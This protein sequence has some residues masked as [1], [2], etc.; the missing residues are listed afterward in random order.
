MAEQTAASNDGWL[1]LLGR[2]A[3]Y[4]T[5]RDNNKTAERLAEIN[6]AATRLPSSPSLPSF[7]FFPGAAGGVTTASGPGISNQGGGGG[8]SIAPFIPLV[9]LTLVG[10]FA[11]KMLR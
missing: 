8:F 4:L 2:G 11:W 5:N 3:D 6:A 7:P 9:V 1:A 10:V